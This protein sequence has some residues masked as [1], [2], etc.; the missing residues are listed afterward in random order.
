MTLK[1]TSWL[2]T[3]PGIYDAVQRLAGWDVIAGAL[4]SHLR[5][6]ASQVV[7]EVGAGTG[8]NRMVLSGEARYVWLD[9]DAHKLTE[10]RR[11]VRGAMG[12]MGD[13]TRLPLC[14][15]SVDATIC[16]C[17]SHHLSDQNLRTLFQEA[18]RVTRRKWVF[19]DA[20]KDRLSFTSRL[21]WRLD[22][23]RHPRQGDKI[24]SLMRDCFHVDHIERHTVY[25]EYLLCVGRPKA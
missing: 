1:F 20:V 19:V 13:G 11:K 10:F 25:H 8:T 18:A 4:R 9:N 12:I 5:E 23:G 21:L 17:V 16:V 7:L 15:K 6:T 22:Q 14:S 3:L 2:L 24:V